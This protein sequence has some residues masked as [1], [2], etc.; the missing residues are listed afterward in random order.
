MAEIEKGHIGSSFD[1]FLDE[2]GIR[3]ETTEVAVKRV[4]AWQ[5]AQV[6]QEQHITKVEM[7][8]RVGTSRAQLNRLL[9]PNND[10]VTLGLLTRA[11]RA[12]GRNLRLELA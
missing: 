12:V 4:I 11:A 3:E 10:S 8:R 7:A 5:L 6:M 9:D 1:D 2:Q